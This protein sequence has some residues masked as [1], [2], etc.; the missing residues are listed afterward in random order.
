MMMTMMIEPVIMMVVIVIDVSARCRFGGFVRARWLDTG[1]AA[2]A[3]SAHQAT[4]S[5]LMRI[6]SPCV[7]RSR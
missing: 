2:S 5:S 1:D 6:S 7:R 4:S 3:D